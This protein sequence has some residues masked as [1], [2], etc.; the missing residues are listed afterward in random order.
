M[1]GSYQLCS[2]LWVAHVIHIVIVH[3]EHAR[4]SHKHRV[5]RAPLSLRCRAC[6]CGCDLVVRIYTYMNILYTH[7]C[8][9]LSNK[10]KKKKTRRPCRQGR[11]CERT[12]Q[13]VARFM[14]SP[15]RVMRVTHSMLRV[16]MTIR[17]IY[18]YIYVYM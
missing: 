15:C 13:L 18:K 1:A 9:L 11:I 6:S 7:I 2:L 8:I 17:N 12:C 16:H 3:F 10:K 5:S 14:P 4:V